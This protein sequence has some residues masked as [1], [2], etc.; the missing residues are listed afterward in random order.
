[1]LVSVPQLPIV[2][3]QLSQRSQMS[4]TANECHD[5]L[6]HMHIADMPENLPARSPK[7]EPHNFRKR[8]FSAEDRV[9]IGTAT[10]ARFCSTCAHAF[11]FCALHISSFR[12]L[13]K[14]DK[15]CRPQRMRNKCHAFCAL[16]ISVCRQWLPTNEKPCTDGRAFNSSSVEESAFL[17]RSAVK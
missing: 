3:K 6:C 4:G 9:S 8:F 14:T 17:G 2:R 10:R 11:R 1:M 13:P 12:S 15:S 16:H 5:K 7:T